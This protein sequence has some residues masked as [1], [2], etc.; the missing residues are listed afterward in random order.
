MVYRRPLLWYTAL[1]NFW[2]SHFSPFDVCISGIDKLRGPAR[3]HSPSMSLS[4]DIPGTV[5]MFVFVLGTFL[6]VTKR[7]LIAVLFLKGLSLLLSDAFLAADSKR[8]NRTSAGF[9]GVSISF[10][11]QW[12]D[13]PVKHWG[14]LSSTPYIRVS[15]NSSFVVLSDALYVEYCKWKKMVKGMHESKQ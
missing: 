7:P 12:R 9:A 13:C 8:W 4:T 1:W 3:T 14:F 11:S 2:G 10:L 15:S 6:S 5:H